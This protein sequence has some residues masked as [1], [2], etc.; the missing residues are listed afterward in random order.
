MNTTFRRL[1]TAISLA[2]LA[3]CSAEP[4]SPPMS[5]AAPIAGAPSENLLG[6]ITGL[7]QG[8]LSAVVG[9][10]RTSP[11]SAPLT[12]SAT[13]GAAGGT[14]SIPAAGVTVT[15]PKGAV[16]GPTNFVMTA[17]AGALVAYDFAPHGITFAHPLIFTQKLNVTNANLLSAPLLGLGYYSDPSLLGPIGG[18]VSELLSGS[19]NIGTWTFTSTIPHFSGYLMTSGRGSAMGMDDQ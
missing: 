15:V 12:T 3:A 18:L 10:R 8:T 2:L 4:T 11:L 7:L 9:V 16:S 6:S 17:R 13:I 5:S 14:L 19:V 1:G